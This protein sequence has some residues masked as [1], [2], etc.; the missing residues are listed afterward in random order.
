M[1]VC[2][3]CDTS[4]D[5]SAFYA[6]NKIGWSSLCLTCRKRIKSTKDKRR[7]R[8]LQAFKDAV[9]AEL[10]QKTER[11]LE[12]QLRNLRSEFKRF[13]LINRD[14]L[15]QLHN[16]VSATEPSAIDHRTT[17]AITRRE[18]NQARA[19]AIYLEQVE[20]IKSGVKPLPIDEIWR[21]EYGTNPRKKS[22]EEDYGFAE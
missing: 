13:T 10:K 7:Q 21:D 14:K 12:I 15:K 16:K 20:M 22:E 9:N 5:D 11:K 18:E 3:K 19:E 4:Q 1:R 2:T 17:D 8:A 6:L